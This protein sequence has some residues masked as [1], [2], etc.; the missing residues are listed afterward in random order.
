[1]EKEIKMYEDYLSIFDKHNPK[2]MH[3][4][5]HT[6]RVVDYAKT[7][8]N[9]LGIS[10]DEQKRACVCAL[11]HDLGRFPQARDYDTFEDSKSFDHG[12]KSFEI[13]NEYD[14]NLIS[15]IISVD[16][17]DNGQQMTELTLLSTE[18]DV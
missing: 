17:F 18:N 5:K 13:L 8:S 4:Y 1:M 12:D 9:S 3:K 2:I 14:K 6:F 10:E 7:I 16:T 11:F 15:Q